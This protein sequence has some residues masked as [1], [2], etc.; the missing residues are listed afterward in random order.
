LNTRHDTSVQE[1]TDARADTYFIGE[2]CERLGLSFRTVR[3]YDE[4]GVVVPSSRTAG[5]FRLYTDEDVERLR[6]IKRMK[7]LGFS[8]EQMAVLL[9]IRDRLTGPPPEDRLDLISQLSEFTKL[10]RD[11]CEF[12]RKQL[13]YAEDFVQT[14]EAELAKHTRPEPS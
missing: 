4:M 8:L 6:L 7:P 11:Q 9:A 5:G 10:A 1:S 12:L 14:L 2:V 3:H 13:F